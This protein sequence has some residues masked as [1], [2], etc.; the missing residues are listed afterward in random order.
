MR[1][2]RDA[3]K[4]HLQVHMSAHWCVVCV[5]VY[6]DI[7]CMLNGCNSFA[8]SSHVVCIGDIRYSIAISLAV[9][10][11]LFKFSLAFRS[12]CS[13]IYH[14]F[15]L[16]S[17]T[18]YSIVLFSFLCRSIFISYV[19]FSSHIFFSIEIK[20]AKSTSNFHL[21]NEE[22]TSIRKVVSANEIKYF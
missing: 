11:H 2:S 21:T 19:F 4:Y 22:I 13:N 17:G 9:S 12:H 20:H 6:L 3:R 18:L 14:I 15:V 16:R 8:N 10:D 7:I 1:I 5:C